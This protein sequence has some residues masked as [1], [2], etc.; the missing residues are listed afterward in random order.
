MS[1]LVYVNVAYDA[2][3]QTFVNVAPSQDG[4]GAACTGSQPACAGKECP[5]GCYAG[6]QTCC[7]RQPDH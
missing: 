7:T 6:K 5:M 4:E 3:K 1:V 2:A